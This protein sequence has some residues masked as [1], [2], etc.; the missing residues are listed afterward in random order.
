[1]IV[2]PII[3]DPL[4]DS[5]E[6]PRYRKN[7]F[8]KYHMLCFAPKARKNVR[9]AKPNNHLFCDPKRSKVDVL[10]GGPKDILSPLLGMAELSPPSRSLD[11]PVDMVS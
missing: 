2:W 10:G 6:H 4:V 1:M 7:R 5:D 8:P 9:I 11:P 3:L